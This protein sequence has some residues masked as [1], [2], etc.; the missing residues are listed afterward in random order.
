MNIKP[1]FKFNQ[2][3]FIKDFCKNSKCVYGPYY[4][5]RISIGRDDS[6]FYEVFAYIKSHGQHITR[7]VRE[8]DLI[9]KK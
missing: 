4:I 5:D 9:R 8:S 7:I 6:I 2:K 1:K 3:I